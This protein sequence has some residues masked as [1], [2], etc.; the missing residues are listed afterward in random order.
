[1]TNTHAGSE[2]LFR[3]VQP[4]RGCLPW[5]I[6]VAIAV[7]MWVLLLGR[8]LQGKP[9]GPNPMPDPILI[10]FWLVFGLAF[11]LAGAASRLITE[12]HPD[13]VTVQF[14]PFHAHARRIPFESLAACEAVTYE[15][16][17]EYGGWGIR[18]GLDGRAYN[19]SGHEG[20][21]LSLNDGGEIL[22]GSNHPDAL[23]SAII[24]RL[25]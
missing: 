4:L 18:F 25:P 14:I 7:M 22:I 15:P 16:L 23:A 10:L 19:V 24:A 20:V 9:V 5:L 21:R 2:L 11:P 13:S 3:E 17:L 6:V 1:M 12:V 8:L